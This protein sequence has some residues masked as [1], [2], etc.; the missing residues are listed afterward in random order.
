MAYWPADALELVI[1]LVGRLMCEGTFKFCAPDGQPRP[2]CPE[3]TSDVVK[4]LKELMLSAC[5]QDDIETEFIKSN[6]HQAFDYLVTTVRGPA[7]IKT[8]ESVLKNIMS[9]VA[10]NSIRETTFEDDWYSS[11]PGC[12]PYGSQTVTPNISKVHKVIHLPAITGFR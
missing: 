3:T 8:M 11:N 7:S 1:G 6:F 10:P 5:D 2:T 9:L 12:L 4:R